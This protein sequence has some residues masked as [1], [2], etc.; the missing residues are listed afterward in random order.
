MKPCVPISGTSVMS[1]KSGAAAAHSKMWPQLRRANRACVLEC[2]GAPAL[3]DYSAMSLFR[4][5]SKPA[6]CNGRLSVVDFVA[7]V[8]GPDSNSGESGSLD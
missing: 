1:R 3:L 4:Q 8:E 7:A 6:Q 5:L 2:A